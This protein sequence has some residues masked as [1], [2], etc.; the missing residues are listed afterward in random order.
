MNN[1]SSKYIAL[2][3]SVNTLDCFVY[4]IHLM[5]KS[6]W[7]LYVTDCFSEKKVLKKVKKNLLNPQVPNLS[8]FKPAQGGQQNSLY[9]LFWRTVIFL[10]RSPSKVSYYKERQQN[11]K[12]WAV[13]L[14][15]FL[16]WINNQK[17]ENFAPLSTFPKRFSVTSIKIKRK[18]RKWHIW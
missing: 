14:P 9:Q 6:F 15:V 12:L 3:N 10:I 8:P 2:F 11:K 7:F 1:F 13:L 16:V 17:A 5:P 4:F 18:K